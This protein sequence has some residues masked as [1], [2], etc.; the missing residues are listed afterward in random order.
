[1]CF[2]FGETITPDIC[3]S[4]RE[5]ACGLKLFSGISLDKSAFLFYNPF[6]T[7]CTYFPVWRNWYTWQFTKLLPL[8]D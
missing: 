1:M 3:S 2:K 7:G 5:Y 4:E 8:P 6:G